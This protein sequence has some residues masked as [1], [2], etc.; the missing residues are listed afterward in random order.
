[1]GLGKG[2]LQEIVKTDPL[3]PT[4]VVQ[5]HNERKCTNPHWNHQ[6]NGDLKRQNG[7]FLWSRNAGCN[8]WHMSTLTTLKE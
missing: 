3:L 8:G 2:S 7:M 1:M 5:K 6:K 4:Q